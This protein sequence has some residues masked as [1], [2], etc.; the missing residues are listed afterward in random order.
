MK[1]YEQIKSIA[2]QFKIKTTNANKNENH[3]G[4]PYRIRYEF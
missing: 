4:I 3:D 1:S 2:Q